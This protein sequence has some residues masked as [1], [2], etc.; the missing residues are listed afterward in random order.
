MIYHV[1][2]C[3]DQS[4]CTNVD[5]EALVAEARGGIVTDVNEFNRPSCTTVLGDGNS[6][7]AG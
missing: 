6:L 5:R 3:M 2:D 7:G 1:F 4:E